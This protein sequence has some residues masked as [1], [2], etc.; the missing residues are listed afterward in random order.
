MRKILSLVLILC[1]VTTA[2]AQQAPASMRDEWPRVEALKNGAAVHV[3]T[4][5]RKVT[6]AI[7]KVDDQ[8]LS[9]L[10]HGAPLMLT[11]AEIKSVSVNHLGRSMLIGLGI[12]AGG[13]AIIGAAVG[14]NGSFVPRGAAAAALAAV[15][16][17][18]GLI[19]GATTGSFPKT[20]YIR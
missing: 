2:T 14:R 3:R 6:C 9:C 12:G 10:D 15:G 7:S 19:I 5:T 11:R 4:D 20:I 1:G 13:G 16:G 18:I 8:S 17:I